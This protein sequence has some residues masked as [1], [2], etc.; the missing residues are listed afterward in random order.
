MERSEGV[1]D[2]ML[3]FYDGISNNDVSAFDALVSEDPPP[4]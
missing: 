4:S 2:A 1:R 3:R